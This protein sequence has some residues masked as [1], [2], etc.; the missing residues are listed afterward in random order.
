VQAVIARAGQGLGAGLLFLAIGAAGLYFGREL[1]VGSAGEM[2][3]GYAP[4]AIS[5][6]L[7]GLGVVA[8][9]KAVLRGSVPI[10]PVSVRAVAGIVA[11]LGVFAASIATLGLVVA[12]VLTVF[13]AC[14]IEPKLRW[15]EALLLSASVSLVSI[16]LFVWV[17]RIP[18][19]VWP[20]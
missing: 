4:L 14:L 1:E 6:G 2:G 20:V 15:L 18:F 11:A 9:A 17:L 5:W 19:Q 13:A 16:A 7:V 3:P 10:E 8:L 12:A